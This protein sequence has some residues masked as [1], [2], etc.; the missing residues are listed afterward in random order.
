MKQRHNICPDISRFDDIIAESFRELAAMDKGIE[1]N[2]SCYRY[3][4]NDLTP[5]REILRLYRRLGGRIITIGSDS[6]KKE[7]LG[8]YIGETKEE[9]K[10]LGF[11]EYCSY[12]RMRPVF[13]LL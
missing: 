2:T 12:E 5:G 7:D 6:H 13:H 10:K 8:N 3:G 4:L 1:I 11:K 9:L